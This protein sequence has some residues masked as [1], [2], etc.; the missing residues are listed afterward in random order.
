MANDG[1]TTRSF[2]PDDDEYDP[3]FD[4]LG[5]RGIEMTAYLRAAL[6][7]LQEDPDAALAA[8]DPYWPPKRP[9][10]KAAHA[11]PATGP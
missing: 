10:G 3:A 6:R 2:R 8:V 7:F 5:K 9:R 4:L 1:P 11:K